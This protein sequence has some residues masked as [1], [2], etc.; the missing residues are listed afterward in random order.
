MKILGEICILVGIYFLYL[1]VNPAY[2]SSDNINFICGSLLL[3]LGLLLLAKATKKITVKEIIRKTNLAQA[4]VAIS[5][6]IGLW[7]LLVNWHS[8]V[9][10]IQYFKEF[11]SMY[12][13]GMMSLNLLFYLIPL[14][15]I[16]G[17][18][19]FFIRKVWSLHVLKWCFIFKFLFNLMG[20]FSHWYRLLT[21]PSLKNY[22]PPEGAVVQKISVYP[23]YLWFLAYGFMLYVITRPKTKKILNK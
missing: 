20:I 10:H 18:V 11:Y 1:V 7:G 3:L 21:F 5:V 22:I 17:G 9:L 2:Y 15:L 19:A 8:I 4:I 6:F 13:A 12:G 16:I 14:L 23:T